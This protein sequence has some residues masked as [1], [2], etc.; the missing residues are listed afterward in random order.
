MLGLD[1]LVDAWIVSHRVAVL[2]PV[3]RALSAFGKGGLGWLAIAAVLT[4]VRRLSIGELVR[5]ILAIVCTSLVINWAIKPVVGRPRPFE[6]T[7]ALHVIGP[8]PHD[9]SFPSGHAGNAAA[10]A[11]VMSIALPAGRVL[12]WLLALGIGYSRIYLGDHFP[13][14]VVAGG[15]IGAAVGWVVARIAVRSRATA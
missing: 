3:M 1:H 7:P 6:Q 14:D 10:A 8:R 4:I 9:P 11:M 13:L 5:M 2:N 15:V 12:W